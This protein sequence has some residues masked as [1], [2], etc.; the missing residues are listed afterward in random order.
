MTESRRSETGKTNM[1]FSN[2]FDQLSHFSMSAKFV[3]AQDFFAS[4]IFHSFFSISLRDFVIAASGSTG[5]I[6][7]EVLMVVLEPPIKM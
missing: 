5:T 2:H 6:S 3:E 7:G 4:T 1:M